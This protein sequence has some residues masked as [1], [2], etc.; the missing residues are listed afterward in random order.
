M[1]EH[2]ANEGKS[3]S[4]LCNRKHKYVF[5]GYTGTWLRRVRAVA[6]CPLKQRV[7]FSDAKCL[8]SSL[9]KKNPTVKRHTLSQHNLIT[10]L[11]HF[12]C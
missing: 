7:Y 3:C 4:S 11:K 6:T 9:K 10:A 1:A 12:V 8:S 5:C 2:K